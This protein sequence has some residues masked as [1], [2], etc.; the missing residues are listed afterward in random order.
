VMVPEPMYQALLD[1]S[2]KIGSFGH[3]FTFSGHPVTAAVPVKAFEIYARDRV[4]EAAAQKAPQFQARLN[5][6][7]QHPLVGEA[8]GTGL[9][10]AIELVVDKATK[11]SFDPKAGVG[12][13]A[14]RLAEEEGLIV[15]FLPGDSLSIC[16]PLGIT[17]AEIEE[18]FDRL[19]RA[20][21][22]TLD[23]VRR[24]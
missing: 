4:F 21:D 9:I 18:L 3:G 2:R 8:R 13:H 15:R 12:P 23:W 20:L 7:G 14:V 10:G 1:E 16:P 5:A 19:G 24:L 11:Q 6:L 22:R 17:P